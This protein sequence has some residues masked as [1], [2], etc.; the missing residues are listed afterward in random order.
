MITDFEIIRFQS[1]VDTVM[2]FSPGLNV[3]VGDTDS[4]KSSIIRAL[5]LLALNKPLGNEFINWNI[6]KNEVM[7]VSAN[8]SDGSW[9]I[10][11]KGKK[12]NQYTISGYDEPFAALRSGVPKEVKEV[13][14]LSEANIQSQ[15]EQY[16]LLDKTGGQTAS[17]FNKVAK[18]DL[19]ESAV[20][21]IKSRVTETNSKITHINE[22][23]K[24]LEEEIKNLKWVK[25]A[26]IRLDNIRAKEM[27]LE[28]KKDGVHFLR[29]AISDFRQTKKDLS[30][31]KAI[32]KQLLDCCTIIKQ[33]D[34]LSE[35]T[36]S[37][38][39]LRFKISE[40]QSIQS[41]LK[42]FKSLK[43]LSLKSKKIMKIISL[44]DI[45]KN[46]LN[47]INQHILNYQKIDGYIS[48]TSKGISIMEKEIE[49]FKEEMEICPLC[50]SEL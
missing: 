25:K 35:S 37:A 14:K 20:K 38:D 5:T 34:C 15:K 28:E 31:F 21:E 33:H 19:M 27:V 32:K 24:N 43:K 6:K 22:D 8:F 17:E 23:I 2:E 42:R 40:Y 9:A 13:L 41:E 29:E 18:L 3:I 45:T 49:K 26:R 4:G 11:E 47:T 10:R 36:K 7:K 12:I 1:H 16:F 30:K 46:N 39:S 44:Y 50:G 48:E